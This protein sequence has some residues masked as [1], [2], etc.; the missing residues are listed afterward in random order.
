MILGLLLIVEGQT[1]L[2]HEMN[3]AEETF[4]AFDKASY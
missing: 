1:L 3:L 4:E 2:Y